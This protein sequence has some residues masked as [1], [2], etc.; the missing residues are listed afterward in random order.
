MDTQPSASEQVTTTIS[1]VYHWAVADP[2]TTVGLIFA[3][4]GAVFLGIYAIRRL[5]GSKSP[6]KSA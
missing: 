4:A 6:S 2:P 1:T 5:R 3:L